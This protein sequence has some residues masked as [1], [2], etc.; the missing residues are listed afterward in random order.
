MIFDYWNTEANGSGTSYSDGELYNFAAPL[1]LYAIWGGPDVTV[2]FAENDNVSD[3]KVATQTENVSGSLTLFA[4][5]SPSFSD[6]GYTFA[7]WNTQAER[8]RRLLCR[9][10]HIQL[11]ESD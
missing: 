6:T 7:G 9:R 11:L 8:Q 3:S 10:S 2:T 5:L 1:T 4:D